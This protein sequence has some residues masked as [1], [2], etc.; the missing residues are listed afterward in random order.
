MTPDPQYR[1]GDADR[2]QVINSLTDAYAEGRLTRDEFDARLE[3]AQQARTF[4]DLARLTSDLPATTPQ[5]KAAA[6]L[7]DRQRQLRK[8]WAAWIG[9]SALVN[10]IWAA[11]WV[12]EGTGPTGYW[13]IWVMGPWG[14]AMVVASLRDR[15]DRT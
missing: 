15:I 9:V 13:P 7:T 12:S 14:I 1:A 10:M 4:G 11:S 3:L 5:P 2:D 8:G 6:G